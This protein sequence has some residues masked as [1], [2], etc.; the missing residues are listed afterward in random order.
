M[1]SPPFDGG[2]AEE[3]GRTVCIELDPGV[4]AYAR[5]LNL[6]AAY[7]PRLEAAR[8]FRR[9]VSCLLVLEVGGLRAYQ[10]RSLCTG[11]LRVS[12]VRGVRAIAASAGEP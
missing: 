12:G 8:Y 3:T 10:L 4:S 6:I 2:D 11:I 5:V 7:S 9:G 1:R